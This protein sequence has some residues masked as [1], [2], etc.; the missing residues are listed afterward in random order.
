MTVKTLVEADAEADVE[1]F[2]EAEYRKIDLL[3]SLEPLCICLNNHSSR[4]YDKK[5]RHPAAAWPL[6]S[7]Q[8]YY[9]ISF[10]AI[11]TWLYSFYCSQKQR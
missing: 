4:S 3:S 9:A 2:M 5:E 1:V 6:S 8:D 10:I 11:S 7:R